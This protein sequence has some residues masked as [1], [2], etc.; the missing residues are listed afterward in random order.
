MSSQQSPPDAFRESQEKGHEIRDARPFAIVVVGFGML[1]LL[2]VVGIV[3]AIIVYKF[4]EKTNQEAPPP[5]QFQ[6][7]QTQLP[8]QPRIEVQGAKDQ[9]EFRSAEQKQL[10]SYGWIDRERKVVRIPI[11]RAMEVLAAKGLPRNPPPGPGSA[12]PKAGTQGENA[13]PSANSGAPF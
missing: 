8:P 9:N 7:K 2:V 13:N 1:A 3:G 4:M 12:T 6:V 5:P 10:D 11:S